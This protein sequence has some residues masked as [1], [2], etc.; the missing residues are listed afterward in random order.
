MRCTGVTAAGAGDLAA[1]RIGVVIDLRSPL[2]VSQDHSRSLLPGALHVWLPIHGG[3]RSSIVDANG[4]LSLELL[5]RQVVEDSGVDPGHGGVGD[6]RQR[7]GPG[8]RALH[9]RARTARGSS[10]RWRSRPPVST[11]RRSWPTTRRAR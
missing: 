9:G 2:E 5:Y 11:G 4:V 10:S 3:S 6:R 8:P 1:L 7:D